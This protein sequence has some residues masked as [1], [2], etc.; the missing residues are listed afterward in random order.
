M[1]DKYQMTANS[2]Q[3]GQHAIIILIIRLGNLSNPGK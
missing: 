1:D 3:Y 2:H